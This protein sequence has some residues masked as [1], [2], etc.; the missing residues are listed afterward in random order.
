MGSNREDLPDPQ[1]YKISLFI[2]YWAHQ[3]IFCLKW[4]VLLPIPLHKLY[5]RQCLYCEPNL[6]FVFFSCVLTILTALA[7][8]ESP[9]PHP[10]KP[11]IT[12]VYSITTAWFFFCLVL[13]FLYLF[14]VMYPSSRQLISEF[15][16][17]RK[18]RTLSLCNVNIYHCKA[19]HMAG[20]TYFN[21]KNKSIIDWKLMKA[22]Q[23][24]HYP[25]TCV[26]SSLTLRCSP[27][28]QSHPW[29]RVDGT[30]KCCVGITA[31]AGPRPLC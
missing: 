26:L 22:D 14:P 17:W 12:W 30:M 31:A 7:T 13:V 3:L 15:T 27:S 8:L 20:K 25:S 1:L 28:L 2:L 18:K 16:V 5:F 23:T 11:S 21:H 19:I 10:P 24:P 9:P 4:V 6:W 29:S